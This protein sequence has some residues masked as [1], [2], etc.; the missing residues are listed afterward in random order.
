MLPYLK[1]HQQFHQQWL[2]N[3]QLMLFYVEELLKN[4]INILKKKPFISERL[5][6]IVF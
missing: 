3:I 2:I 1:F 6:I 4:D 5:D